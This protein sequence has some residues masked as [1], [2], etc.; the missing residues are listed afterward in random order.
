M[1]SLILSLTHDLGFWDAFFNE[2]AKGR[3][4][5][6][7]IIVFI[8][9]F[10]GFIISLKKEAAYKRFLKM[11]E[12]DQASLFGKE[13][14]KIKS[15][16]LLFYA[17]RLA[18]L[19]KMN[20]R[21]KDRLRK[22]CYCYDIG[23]VTVPKKLLSRSGEL[24]ASEQKVWDAH[25]EMGARIARYIPQLVGI[26]NL[27]ACHE[28]YYDGSG[29]KSIRAKHIPLACRILT[30]ALMYDYYTQPHHDGA[31]MDSKQALAE[32]DLYTGSWLDPD[33]MEAFHKLFANDRLRSAL[34]AKLYW[35]S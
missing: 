1:D 15:E 6:R 3:L 12:T 18:T 31:I 33:V 20:P 16:R 34:V 19:L 11:G 2:A 22:L 29:Q 10:A 25:I 17:L 26:S 5:Y 7:L 14:S 23:L 24:D 21:E 32:M 4:I 27:I 8:I 35:Q 13:D 28:E 30:V 9:L